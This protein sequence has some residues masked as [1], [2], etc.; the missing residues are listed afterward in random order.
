MY[1]PNERA[2]VFDEKAHT[3]CVTTA[4]WQRI[5]AI[6]IPNGQGLF[7]LVATDNGLWMHAI[8]TI[9]L[10]QIYNTYGV[11]GTIQEKIKNILQKVFGGNAQ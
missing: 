11:A 10:N 7:R 5:G 2:N 1:G 6:D 3:L 4:N 9:D 8:S